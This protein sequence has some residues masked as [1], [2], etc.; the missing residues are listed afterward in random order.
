MIKKLRGV[1]KRSLSRTQ[2][3][4]SVYPDHVHVLL[5]L[6]QTV[7]AADLLKEMKGASSHL[8]TH[9]IAPSGKVD[10]VLSRSAKQRCKRCAYTSRTRS[11][12]MP[13]ERH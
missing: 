3:E 7:A 4:Y 8:A 13:K 10:M 12:C 9:V 6:H 5:K 1:L 2:T 11:G